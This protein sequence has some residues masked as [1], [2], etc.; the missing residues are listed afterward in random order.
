MISGY[1]IWIV[2]IICVGVFVASFID[3][4]GGGG[5]L[6]SLPVYLLSG[7]PPHL[8]LAT[9]KLSATIGTTASTAR[10]IKKGFFNLKLAI[11]SIVLG[12]GGSYIGA[13]LQLSLPEK[14]VKYVLVA[15]L[16]IIAVIMLKKKTFSENPEYIEPKKQAAI[17]FAASLIIG[18]YDGF[19]GPGT[20]TFLYIAFCRFAKMDLKTAAGNVKLVNLASNI[21]ALVTYLVA[22]KAII[23]IGLIAGAFAF[24]GQF[25]GA[26]LL[27]K[28]STKIVTPVILTVLA[29]L[30]VKTILELCGIAI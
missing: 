3:A 25:V 13:S 10:Y 28:N 20:G 27:I 18:I 5:G 11:P 26:G 23:T 24:A 15:I 2:A 7:L 29:I 19:Y 8:A 12:V 4:I 9:N 6:I 1:P 21:G 22:G 16:P 17:V 14:Y 30:L